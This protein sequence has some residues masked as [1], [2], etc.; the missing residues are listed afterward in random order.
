MNM[1]IKVCGM[2]DAE[3]IAAV[4]N[5]TPDFMGLIFYPKSS[6]FVGEE[7]TPA[8]AASFA[9]T[10]KVGVFVNNDIDYI[11]EKRDKFHLDLVQ[12]HGNESPEFCKE[13]I[14]RG[15]D[16]IKAFSITDISDIE[17]VR[18]YDGCTSLNLL[19]TKTPKV[20]GSGVKFD[21]GILDHYPSATPFLLSGGIDLNDVDEVKKIANPALVGVDLNSK[22]E[23]SPA[24]KDVDK[25]DAFFKKMRND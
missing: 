23:V 8:Q 3:N 25:L 22:F 11:L 16:V 21:W 13:L 18:D 6:R 1:L 10:K 5:L 2:R 9:P 12:L 7:P 15:V 20:G 19:D 14:A 24:L 17:K 4:K